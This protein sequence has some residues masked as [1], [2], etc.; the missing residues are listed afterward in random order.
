MMRPSMRAVARSSYMY[1][2]SATILENRRPALFMS[3]W[4][5]KMLTAATVFCSSQEY[6]IYSCY[7]AYT[8]S[9]YPRAHCKSKPAKANYF[10]LMVN[11]TISHNNDSDVNTRTTL[12]EFN[13]RRNTTCRCLRSPRKPKE[14][15]FSQ[16]AGF[17]GHQS[18]VAILVYRTSILL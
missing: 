14:Y 1:S 8:H 16:S 17:R 10:L 11:I 2:V 13:P 18:Q 9:D 5:A 6:L 7:C 3:G 15:Y 12:F 4:F